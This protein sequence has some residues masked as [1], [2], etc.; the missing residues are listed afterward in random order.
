MSV[1]SMPVIA[2]FCR[3]ANRGRAFHHSSGLQEACA[4]P[5]TEA[6]TRRPPPVFRTSQT[7]PGLH[8]E[9][10]VGLH[11]T[12]SPGDLRTTFPHGF[13]RRFQQQIKTFGEACIMV[14]RPGLE[15]VG[16]LKAANY[17]HPVIRY[18]IYGEKGC[19]KTLTLCNA[20]QYCA[21]QNWLILY[22]PDAYLWVKHCKELMPS[23]YNQARF[24]QPLE[25]STWL[26]NFRITNERFL[27]ELKT[28]QKYTWSKREA[29][30]E[31]RPLGEVVDQGIARVKNASDV[32]GV[33]FKELKSQCLPDTYRML[34]AV[35]GVNALWGPT[36]MKKED[37]SQV[38]PSE[39]TLIHNLRKLLSND[40]AGGAMVTTLT[41]TGALGASQLSYLPLELLRKDGFDALDPFVPI[42]VT[43]Y[44][45]KEFESCYQYYIDR[46]W[47]Q[48]EKAL[49]EEGKQELIFLSNYNPGTF[50]RICSPL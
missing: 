22:V 9:Q 17:S 10:H 45:Q 42:Q 4:A 30:E 24:D 38:L 8:T 35:D 36:T 18:V 41:Q 3:L 1:R 5:Q 20:V 28:R 14:R 47:I 19:G 34:V 48:H 31:G 33:L 6:D 39:L 26:K 16:Y 49:S 12:L 21:K 40:W 50:D 27:A 46:K 23:T 2:R 25:A 32:V 7:D 43:N 44:T 29:T 13:T 15:L 37:K 11:Y